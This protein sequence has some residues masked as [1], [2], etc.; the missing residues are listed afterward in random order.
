MVRGKFYKSSLSKEQAAKLGKDVGYWVNQHKN[1]TI[2]EMRKTRFAVLLH[3]CGDHS[4][5]G[6]WCRAQRAKKEGK[7]YNVKPTIDCNTKIGMKRIIDVYE[8]LS[9]YTD[10]ESLIEML[11]NFD[12]QLNKSLNMRIAETAPKSK[13]FSRLH[14]L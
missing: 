1:G 4:Q 3:N 2:K 8:I 10:N 13:N 7:P 5:C 14:S 9:K 11:H 6:E 12:T